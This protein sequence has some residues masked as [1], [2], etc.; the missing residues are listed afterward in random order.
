MDMAASDH[1]SMAPM[2]FRTT[3]SIWSVMCIAMMAPSALPMIFTFGK[4]TRR[5][6]PG[7]SPG[8]Q[9]I[10]LALFVLT[11]FAAWG[12]FGTLA[13]AAEWLLGQYGIVHN[14]QLQ[15]R[16]VSGALL[17]FSGLYQWSAIKNF[18]LSKCRS[19]LGFLLDHYHSGYW[20]A[21]RAGAVHAIFCLGCCWAV[22]LLAWVGGAMNLI[23]MLAI[24]LLVSAEKLLGVGRWIAGV[25]A[26]AL[27]GLGVLEIAIPNFT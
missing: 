2:Y 20:G 18:C 22:M 15:S 9:A 17:V 19:P 25:S 27:A 21:L 24:T 23:W 8:S 16:T 12:A 11:Y 14:G 3:I 26:V 1:L 13:G 10:V 5:L 7:F 6:S 4:V